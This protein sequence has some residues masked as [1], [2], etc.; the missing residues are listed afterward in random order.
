MIESRQELKKNYNCEVGSF[1]YSL[2][3]K[4]YF[5]EDLY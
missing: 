3:E 5:D 1:I 4:S 2:H